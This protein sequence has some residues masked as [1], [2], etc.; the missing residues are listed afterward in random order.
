MVQS[1]WLEFDKRQMNKDTKIK[2]IEAIKNRFKCAVFKDETFQNTINFKFLDCNQ[3]KEVIDKLN[4]KIDDKK[5]NLDNHFTTD[6]E[7]IIWFID[8]EFNIG[9]IDKLINYT[10]FRLGRNVWGS[11]DYY[12]ERL[13]ILRFILETLKKDLHKVG[14][15]CKLDLSDCEDHYFKDYR[16]VKNV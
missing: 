16:G 6:F 13:N 15:K 14:V 7:R 3:I 1:I 9:K 4:L 10:Y 5:A 11:I 12:K 2:V 8:L